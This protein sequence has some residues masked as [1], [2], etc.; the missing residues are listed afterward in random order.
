[1]H[2]SPFTHPQIMCFTSFSVRNTS[3]EVQTAFPWGHM[4]PHLG[5]YMVAWTNPTEHLKLN[6]D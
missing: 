1:M 2:S 6:F 5:P 4:Y 3:P